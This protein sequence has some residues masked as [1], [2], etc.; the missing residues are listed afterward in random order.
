V[1]VLSGKL[2]LQKRLPEGILEEINFEYFEFE[3]FTHRIDYQ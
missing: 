2:D 3:K 1:G